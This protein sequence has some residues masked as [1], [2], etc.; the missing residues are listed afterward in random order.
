M[1]EQTTQWYRP[2]KAAFTLDPAQHPNATR[3]NARRRA[4]WRNTYATARQRAAPRALMYA[5][6]MQEMAGDK[7]RMRLD[8]SYR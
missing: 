1:L 5:K 6:Y 4:V 8:C 2:T 3:D 7:Q